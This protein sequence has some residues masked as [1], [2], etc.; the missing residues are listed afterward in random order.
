[1]PRYLAHLDSLK[2]TKRERSPRSVEDIET[3]L[4]VY[5]L[6]TLGHRAV[7]S[8]DERDIA[9][10][11]RSRAV[12]TKSKA[13]A[14]NVLSSCSG[15]FAWA[16]R[17]KLCAVNAVQVARAKFGDELVP[18]TE[19]KEG[20]ALTDDEVVSALEHVSPTFLPVV[21]VAYE[22]GLRISEVLG[23]TWRRV[24]LDGATVEVAQQLAKDGTIRPMLKNR[25]GR[26]IPISRKCA[27][28]LRAHKA[29]QEEAGF[30][31][32]DT[33]LCFTTASG[34]ALSRR[35]ALRAWQGALKWIGVTD[36]G[37]HS[38]RSTFVSRL[39]ERN[40]PLTVAAELCGHARTATTDKHYARVR[41]NQQARIEAMR[42]VLV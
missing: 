4:R 26:E 11:A 28:V 19:A 3:K 14:Q 6:P 24:D 2:G 32:K 17:E 27:N 23:L 29:A 41:G 38:L 42:E 37:L 40:V 1:M 22:T 7:A 39:A 31:V 5:L 34:R 21:Q 15:F 10:L 8:V 13:T 25:K 9:A 33:A 16:L 30:S 18:A 20:R 35:N 36:A 12:S